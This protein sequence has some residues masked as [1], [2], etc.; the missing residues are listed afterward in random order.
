[1]WFTIN[2]TCTEIE[3]A[4]NIAAVLWSD[5]KNEKADGRQTFTRLAQLDRHLCVRHLQPS[6]SPS[7][8][9]RPPPAQHTHTTFTS[10]RINDFQIKHKSTERRSLLNNLLLAMHSN[11]HSARVTARHPSE[12]IILFH[13]TFLSVCT[14]AATLYAHI[15]AAT[16]RGRQ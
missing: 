10:A 11:Q 7:V 9:Y 14:A 1:M 16:A 3:G 15:V 13:C 4:I 8:I 12:D 2:E 6:R 5:E